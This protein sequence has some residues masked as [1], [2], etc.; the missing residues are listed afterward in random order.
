M[1]V[2]PLRLDRVLDIVIEFLIGEGNLLSNVEIHSRKASSRS[3]GD[4]NC[5]FVK[6]GIIWKVTILDEVEDVVD[7][8][9]VVVVSSLLLMLLRC[10]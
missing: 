4:C 5:S 7:V 8:V 3:W 9:V 2:F 1:T 6:G 10:C